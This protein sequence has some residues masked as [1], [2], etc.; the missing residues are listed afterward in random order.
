MKYF[1]LLPL[2][3]LLFTACS[4]DDSA[5][6]VQQAKSIQTADMAAR[7]A[8]DP[9]PVSVGMPV[10]PT[11]FKGLTA[12]V[13]I[14]VSGGFT[15]PIVNFVSNVPATVNAA[16]GYRV[17]VI[18]QQLADCEDLNVIK[19]EPAIFGTSAIY[20]NVAAT[21]PMVTV[22]PS[23]FPACYKWRIVLEGVDTSCKSYSPW[24]DAPLF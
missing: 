11:C 14:D 18:I 6:I 17:K 7:S 4:I 2:L 21:H 3:L 9:T 12:Y 1:Y 13:N 22:A 24:Y 8:V 20:Y 19:G 10:E 15:N 5:D 16:S 23:Q